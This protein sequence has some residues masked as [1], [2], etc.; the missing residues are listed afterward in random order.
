MLSL[1]EPDFFLT[2]ELIL[3]LRFREPSLRRSKTLPRLVGDSFL[4]EDIGGAGVDGRG[5][6][7]VG[8]GGLR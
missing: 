2:S 8:G 3:P 4:G 5:F 1:K 6:I 7:N